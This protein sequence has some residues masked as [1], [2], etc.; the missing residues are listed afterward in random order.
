MTR[1]RRT[2][3]ISV[4]ELKK[5]VLDM[6][7]NGESRESLMEEYDLSAEAL[8]RWIGEASLAERAEEARLA[9]E[10]ARL[11]KENARLKVERDILKAVQEILL[12][13]KSGK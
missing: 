7:R 1:R 12:G 13:E 2:R 9:A 8:D 5:Q 11:R 10:L 4:K 3:R 6:Y